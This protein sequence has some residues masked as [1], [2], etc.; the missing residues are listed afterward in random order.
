MFARFLVDV[1]SLVPCYFWVGGEESCIYGVEEGRQDGWPEGD[2]GKLVQILFRC[3][4]EDDGVAG[5][6]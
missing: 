3:F 5:G 2:M 6:E 4:R 1:F